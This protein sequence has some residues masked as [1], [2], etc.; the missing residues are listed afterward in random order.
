MLLGVK[1]V[2]MFFWGDSIMLHIVNGGKVD[3]SYP[4]LESRKKSYMKTSPK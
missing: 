4:D 1:T 3:S 2:N